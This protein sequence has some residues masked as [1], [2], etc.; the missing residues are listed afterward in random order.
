MKYVLRKLGFYLIALWAALTLNF[1]LPRIMPGNP[2]DQLISKLSQKGQVTPATRHAVEL[3]LG[4]DSSVPMW[5]QYLSYFGNIFR[6]DLGVSATY[7]P[8]SVS[9]VIGNTLPWTVGL[10][11]ISTILAFVFGT[12]L[13]TLA[14]WKRGSWIDNLIPVTTLFQS[15]PYFWLALILLYFFGLKN[16]IFPL[17]GGYDVWSVTPGWSW[18]FIASVIKYGM[19]PAITIVLSSVGGWMLGM[20]NMMVS[21]LSE[22]YILT[23]EAKGLSRFKIMTSYAARNA[24]L[25]SISGF[26][27]SLGFVV[28]G[29]IVAESVFSYPGIGFALLTAVQNNDYALMQGI[30]MIITISVL[31]ANLFMDLIYGLIDPRTRAQG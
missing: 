31:G 17:F 13:G 23:A 21:T 16:P 1:F 22:D 18:A 2:V 14:G 25:P 10:V 26:A 30:F 8:N 15:I 27:I 11:G 24:I 6:G 9:S 19:L 5:Q 28:A 20:R 3:M 7:F 29:S 4:S 12:I